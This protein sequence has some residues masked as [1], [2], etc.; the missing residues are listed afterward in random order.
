M[1][2]AVDSVDVLREIALDQHGYVT[3]RQAMEAGV[4]QP[5]LSMLVRRGRVER[6]A[7]GR[8]IL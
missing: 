6:V 2:E 8:S 5:A 7:R 3:W 1:I 4:S